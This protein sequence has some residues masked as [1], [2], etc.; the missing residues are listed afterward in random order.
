LAEEEE[1]E[2]DA[3]VEEVEEEVEGETVVDLAGRL[4][5][6]LAWVRCCF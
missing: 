3:E 4:F 2:E 6:F 1:E 5:C